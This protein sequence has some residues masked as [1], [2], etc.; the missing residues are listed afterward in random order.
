MERRRFL[1]RLGFGALGAVSLPVLTTTPGIAGWKG[2]HRNFHLLAMSAA[3]PEGGPRAPRNQIFMSGD[4]SFNPEG[5]E[6]VGGGFY[7]HFLFPGR[8]PIPGELGLPI[9]ASGTWKARRALRYEEVATWGVEAG[10]R[11]ELIVDLFRQIPSKAVIHAAQLEIFSI[12][13]FAF[14]GLE[15]GT[16][17]S[18]QRIGANRRIGYTLSVPGTDFSLGGRLGPFGPLDPPVGV[19]AFSTAL[20]S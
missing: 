5:A 14:A 10:G 18:L 11:L 3:G 17:P 19:T 15:Q 9:V 12:P 6:V 20:L 4:G 2:P 1:R 13:P 8:A 7:V 16:Q